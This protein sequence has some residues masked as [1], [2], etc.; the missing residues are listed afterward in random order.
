M[1]YE[2]LTAGCRVGLLDLP[3]KAHSRVAK[4][5]MGLKA[6]GLVSQFP[7]APRQATPLKEASRCA[8]IILGRWFS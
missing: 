1:V 7:S 5:V 6:K 2:A 3:E 4:G 8:A